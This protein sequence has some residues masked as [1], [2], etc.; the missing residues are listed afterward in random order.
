[1]QLYLFNNI[2]IKPFIILIVRVLDDDELEYINENMIDIFQLLID[3]NIATKD[4]LLV[5]SLIKEHTKKIHNKILPFSE[6]N[7]DLIDTFTNNII[8][9]ELR[10]N[11]CYT[12]Y[13]CYD[14]KL[15]KKSC[16]LNMNFLINIYE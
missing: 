6:K 4:D 9:N 14:D 12:F 10:Q 3:D 11:N 2:K 8:I 7:V 15:L 16:N 1:M 13:E 5:F